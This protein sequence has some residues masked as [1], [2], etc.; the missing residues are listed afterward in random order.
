MR[1][2]LLVLLLLPTVTL[3]QEPS[4]N[5]LTEWMTGSFSS[6]AQAEQDT[7]YFHIELEMARI[8]PERTDGVWLY[9]EQASATKKHKPY[10]QRVY[11]VQQVND[12]TF[13]SSIMKIEN[14]SQHCGAYADP[15]LLANLSSEA[16]VPLDGCTITL[17]WRDGTFTGSTDGS[18][19]RNAWGEA[20]YA[21]SEVTITPD[22]LVSWDRGYNDA[23]EQVWGAELGGYVFEKLR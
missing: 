9:V 20:S 11:W 4:L 1:S 15:K 10:R 18:S 23:D 8:W 21:T 5:L 12:S 16:L 17:H 3:A 2:I 22:R 14:G 7:N 6:A 19:C 13:T